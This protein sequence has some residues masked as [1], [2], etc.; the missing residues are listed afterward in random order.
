MTN[1]TADANVFLSKTYDI[2]VVGGGTAG[3]ALASRLSETSLS[4]GVIE[5]GIDKITTDPILHGAGGWP[6][7]ARDPK[8]HWG[9]SSILQKNLLGPTPE[10]LGRRA[11]K[12]EYDALESVFGNKGWN[13]D[14]LL[15]YFLKSQT[16]TA[17]PSELFS[18]SKVI[19]GVHGTNGPVNT[20]QNWWQST[21]ID[22][23]VKTLESHS[24]KFNPN[25]DGGNPLGIINV[26]R[27]VHPKTSRRQD[28]AETYLKATQGRDN[29]TVLVGAHAC[30]VIFAEG[31]GDLVATGVEIQVGDVKHVVNASK[32]VILSAEPVSH[33]LKGAYQ[34]P[35]LLELSGIGLR[36]VLEKHNIETKVELPVGENMQDHMMVYISRHIKPES[37]LKA[38]GP[39]QSE[40]LLPAGLSVKCVGTD[41]QE[42][43]PALSAQ[44]SVTGGPFLLSHLKKLKLKN[45]SNEEEVEKLAALLEK[46]AEETQLPIERAQLK[47]QKYWLEN[48]S[49]NVPEACLIFACFPGLAGIPTPDGGLTTWLP[50]S[51]LRPASRGSVHIGSADPLAAPVVDVNCL[52]E[53]DTRAFLLMARF[54]EDLLRQEPFSSLIVQEPPRSDEELIKYIRTVG[55]VMFH[56]I[57]TTPMASRELGGVVDADL[58][59]YGTRNLRVVDAG[60]FPIQISAM[61]QASIYAVA[62]KAAD[63]I[64]SRYE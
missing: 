52:N 39:N 47:L 27:G 55:Q 9:F 2:I 37:E 51:H 57:S 29:I 62:E 49:E 4:I 22:P 23:F 63:I 14:S 56:P 61:P 46:Q 7:T 28:A 32:E 16:H 15:P 26:S 58:I 21:L 25:P 41:G 10:E 35:Q 5:A 54:T 6:L 60:I 19:P 40:P 64:K 17:Q 3:L 45:Q 11:S 36:R 20:S 50:L 24:F 38:V 53:Y 42:N 48:P 18:E 8:Y 44:A 59:V 30:R 1:I 13:F 12:A 34:S 43:N 33:T 31:T